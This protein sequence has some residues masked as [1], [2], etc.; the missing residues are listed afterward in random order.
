MIEVK[1]HVR[2]EFITLSN[3]WGAV[4]KEAPISTIFE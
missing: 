4:Q 2:I 3:K 1:C